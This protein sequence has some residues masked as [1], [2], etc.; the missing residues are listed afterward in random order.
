MN[1]SIYTA[2]DIGS[3]NIKIISIFYDQELNKTKILHKNSYTTRGITDGYISNPELFHQS[4]SEALLKYKKETGITVKEAVF[5]ISSSALKAKTLKINHQTVNQSTITDVDVNEIKR[6]INLFAEKNIPGK[7]LDSKLINY[8][9]NNYKYFSEIEGMESKKIEA[10]YIFIFLPQNHLSTLE[11]ILLKNDIS[12]L[13]IFSANVV[14][15]EI[16]IEKEDRDLGV[17]NID[18]GADITSFSI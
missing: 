3:K 1:E 5:T 18:M 6:K 13:N 12:I 14:S 9:I 8:K 11:K 4:F 15:A 17:L 10:E 7:I 16:N 2:I